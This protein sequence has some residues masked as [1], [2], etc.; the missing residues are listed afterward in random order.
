MA[1][2][3]VLRVAGQSL[4]G[5]RDVDDRMVLLLNVTEDKGTGQ[6]NC[7]DVDLR[8]RARGHPALGMMFRPL[9]VTRRHDEASTYE[10]P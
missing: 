7:A 4:K 6:I 5:V 8:I 10:D 2:N 3:L 9:I 1:D